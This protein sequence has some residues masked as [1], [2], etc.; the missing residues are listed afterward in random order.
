MMSI[1]SILYLHFS[2]W[3]I[4]S[5]DGTITDTTIPG[6]SEPRSNGNEGITS[7]YPELQK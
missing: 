7:L 1:I 2:N 6:Q 3:S 5:L 4:S